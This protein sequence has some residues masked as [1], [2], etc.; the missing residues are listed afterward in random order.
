MTLRR[1]V[2]NRRVEQPQKNSGFSLLEMIVV[3]GVMATLS[4]FFLVY[5]RSGESQIKILNEKGKF[6]STLYRARALAIQTYQFD[7]PECGYG[8]HILA[9]ENPPR[10]YLLWRDTVA[11]LGADCND[12]DLSARSNGR[13]DAVKDINGD[14]KP[15]EDVQFFSLPEGLQ[16]TDL[17]AVDAMRDVLFV[18]PDPRV[19]LND[20]A[21][22]GPVAIGIA[23]EDGTSAITVHINNFGQVEE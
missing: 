13:Y 9:D 11:V 21:S 2:Y 16:F 17:G 5:T 20:G 6:I 23:K 1:L 18:P 8:I 4:G 15:D 22:P 3:L 10:R 7:P 12:E 14:G 19:T